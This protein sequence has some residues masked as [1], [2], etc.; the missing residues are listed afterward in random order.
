MQ[1][2]FSSAVLLAAYPARLR[3]RHGAE[4][5]TTMAEVAGPAGP[6]RAERRHFVLDGLRERFR[7]PPQRP[8]AVVAA[9]LALLI[10]GALGAAAGSWAGMWAYPTVPAL[11]PI[12]ARALGSDATMEARPAQLRLW[13]DTLGT[14]GPGVDPVEAVGRARERLSAAGWQT[15]AVEVSGGTDGI[16]FRRAEFRAEKSGV[17]LELTAYYDD[18]SLVQLGAWSQRPPVY[19]PLVLGGMALGLL[20]GWLSAAALAYRISG[21]HRRRASAV[22]AG[23][24]LALLLL[25][26]GSLY[27]SLVRYLPQ[28]RDA[29][30][31]DLVHR[32]LAASPI[33]AQ[34][35]S[36][37]LG[38]S[39]TDSPYLNK[40]LVIAGLAA[41]LAAAILAR[42]G[43]GSE[44]P[45]GPQPA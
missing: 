38:L 22:T 19:A 6:T 23:A 42:P 12:A 20:A 31:T 33:S 17:G 18:S 24:G 43:R 1:E 21:A 29:G 4:L 14:L 44:Q 27:L 5:I 10:G 41:V 32:A 2:P 34:A 3:R 45:A 7:L 16:H 15:D 28:G 36:L 13:S 25:P 11:G 9:V 30:V 39:W 26:A 37:N 8:L 40:V 35:D